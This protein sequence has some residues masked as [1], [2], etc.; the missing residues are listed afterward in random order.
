VR[1]GLLGAKRRAWEE[2]HSA[3]LAAKQRKDAEIEA[4]RAKV[5]AARKQRHAA[6]GRL[7]QR[8]ARGQPV[9]RHA[10]ERLL[11]QVERAIER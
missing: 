1:I 2:E 5:L 9:M 4:A 8:T 3:R 10:M 7:S 11:A 6:N